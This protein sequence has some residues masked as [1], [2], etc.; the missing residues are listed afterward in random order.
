MV[1]HYKMLFDNSAWKTYNFYRANPNIHPK[2]V[3]DMLRKSNIIDFISIQDYRMPKFSNLFLESWHARVGKNIDKIKSYF[4]EKQ[5]KTKQK[6]V[7]H[8]ILNGVKSFHSYFKYTYTYT[9]TIHKSGIPS[10]FGCLMIATMK[11]YISLPTL[12]LTWCLSLLKMF[13]LKLRNVTE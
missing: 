2:Y 8:K 11:G 6:N 13:C 3:S 4:S 5:N 9:H 12:L 10:W 7:L 1:V